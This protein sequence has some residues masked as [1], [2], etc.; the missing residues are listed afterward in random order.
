MNPLSLV[1]AAAVTIGSLT[2]CIGTG[3][4]PPTIKVTETVGISDL[5]KISTSILIK[6][7]ETIGLSDLPQVV[8]PAVVNVAEV[9]GV[10]DFSVVKPQPFIVSF[11]AE[12]AI[13]FSG[14]TSTLSWQVLSATSVNLY[15]DNSSITPTG[16]LNV[17]P[18]GTT[19][20]KL[21]ASNDIATVSAMV[22]VTVIYPEPEPPP[23]PIRP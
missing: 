8:P 21:E 18:F 6:V 14:G 23:P 16:T 7:T 12:P 4:Q 11:K 1:I 20:Y 2:S 22:T 3:S 9:I 5:P 17:S 13:I 19:T 10:T 15:P